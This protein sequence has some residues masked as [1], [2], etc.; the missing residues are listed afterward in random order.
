MATKDILICISQGPGAE[1]TRESLLRVLIP[2]LEAAGAKFKTVGLGTFGDGAATIVPETPFVDMVMEASKAMGHVPVLTITFAVDD[3][4]TAETA[5]RSA[6]A[7]TPLQDTFETARWL[8]ESDDADDDEHWKSIEIYYDI[9][10]IPDGYAHPLDFR[11]EAM[12]LIG[13][14]LEGAGAGEWSGADCGM[15]EVNFGFTVSDFGNAEDIVR[16]TV[17]GTAYDCIREITRFDSS[18]HNLSEFH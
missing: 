14:A 2:T 17:A 4:E 13:A 8:D 1:D 3:F 12:E 9:G 15:G 10:A 11:N 5:I 16:K 7:G 18:E 6:V